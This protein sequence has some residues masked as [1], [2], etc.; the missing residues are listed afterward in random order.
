MSLKEKV[1]S[2]DLKES[3]KSSSLMA[4]APPR[5]TAVRHSVVSSIGA[6]ASPRS[7]YELNLAQAVTF[8]I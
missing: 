4:L 2:K 6:W 1:T 3:R 7:L 8:L 5:S